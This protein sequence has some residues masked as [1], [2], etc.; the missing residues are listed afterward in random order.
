MDAA[1]GDAE[2]AWQF[3]DV[4]L[5]RFYSLPDETLLKQSSHTFMSSK[6]SGEFVVMCIKSIKSM[7]GM[8]PHGLKHWSGIIEDHFFLLE[9]PGLDVSQLGISYSMYQDKEDQDDIEQ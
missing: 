6:L 8:I 3:E 1:E 9:K 5:I 4:A 2:E 7:V